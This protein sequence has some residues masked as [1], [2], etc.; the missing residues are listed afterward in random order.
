MKKAIFTFLLFSLFYKLSISQEI[1]V[2]AEVDTNVILIGE[3]IKLN[4]EIN[5]PKDVNIDFPE[6]ENKLDPKIE[7]LDKSPMDSVWVDNNHLKVSQQMILTSFDTGLYTIPPLPFEL[8]MNNATDTIFS[9]PIRLG[10]FTMQLDTAQA[11]FDIKG[12]EETPLTFKELLPY[13]WIPV[14]L[15]LLAV[16]IYYLVYIKKN[17][18][19]LFKAPEK[20]LPPP[21]IEAFDSLDLLKKE[22]LWQH[23]KVKEYYSRLTGIL[24]RYIERRYY[25]K[26]MEQT[27]NEIV[28][29]F[30]Q[31]MLIDKGMIEE[32]RTLLSLADFIKFAKG[33]ALP[34]ENENNFDKVWQ[35][36]EKTKEVKVIYEEN[37]QEKEVS[38]TE[39]VTE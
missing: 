32:L 34:D 18:K 15:I 14:S 24:R 22:K 37:N 8:E 21:H 19:K 2:N 28:S 31:N 12:Q 20:P 11:I 6:I 23:N 27:S 30:A 35:F 25:V 16:I 10:V 9:P 17:D 5:K 3:Q 4:L 33:S 36:V 1:W 39:K 29:N 38:N 13:W 7:I 26:A